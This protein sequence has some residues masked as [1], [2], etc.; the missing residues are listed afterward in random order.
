M[1]I[2]FETENFPAQQT[3]FDSKARYK[4]VVKGRRFGLT[5]GAA[6]DFINEALEDKYKAGL[7]VD[8]VNAN[9]EKYVERYFIP[10]LKKLPKTVWRWRKQAKILDIKNSYIDFRSA[11]RPENI[12]GFGYDKLFINE[13]GIVLKDE[14]LW[15][16]AIKPMLWDYQPRCVIGGT[17]KGM[18][19]FNK[20]AEYGK[21]KD[22]PEYEY[23]HFT[24]YDNPYLQLDLLR[25]EVKNM[26]ERVVRQEVYAEFLEDTGVVFRN[27]SAIADALPEKPLDEHTYVIGC[28]L[29]KVTD[30]T[31]ISVYDRSN[32]K[33][34]YQDRFNKLE[35]P[36]QKAKIK[37]V[38]DHYNRALVMLDATGLGDPIADD[39][40]R[41]GV[42]IEPI[43]LTNE[44]KKQIVEKLAIFI[45][46]RHIHMLNI[47]DTIKEFNNFT[48]D[49]SA[50]GRVMYQSPQGFNDDIVI[51]HA[52]AVWS[53]NP[54][55]KATH[56]KPKT[57][58]QEAY[59]EQKILYEE[60]DQNLAELDE[61]NES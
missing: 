11:D 1:Q 51:S 27:V 52:L 36:F 59:E 30:F 56:E 40:T 55:Y 37:S 45:E 25:E 9:I 15:D 39:L 41:A 48:Y 31:V 14:Y 13:A 17:P 42:P 8:T 47:E 10:H 43:K 21:D 50:S 7:W 38:S 44:T 24:S 23:F 33:Q 5:K 22:K 29:A 26:P 4:I 12:E 34:V 20:L 54:L 35:W 16:N 2:D 57:P 46:Q 18:G 19:I 53:L 32:N 61:W 58:L 6:N 49:I 28:D 60:T 3:I